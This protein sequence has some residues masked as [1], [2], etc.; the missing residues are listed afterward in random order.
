MTMRLYCLFYFVHIY[1]TTIVCMYNIWFVTVLMFK[2]LFHRNVYVTTTVLRMQSSNL[3]VTGTDILINAIWLVDHSHCLPLVCWYISR[4]QSWCTRDPGD[5]T[6]LKWRHFRGYLRS[7]QSWWVSSH[8]PIALPR[9]QI[10]IAVM[11]LCTLSFLINLVTY[12]NIQMSYFCLDILR[13]YQTQ[14]YF[15]I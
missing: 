4:V 7:F 11:W 10:Y 1:S 6:Q 13:V 9:M 8:T 5:Q 3:Y 2:C 12:F 15:I 14:H